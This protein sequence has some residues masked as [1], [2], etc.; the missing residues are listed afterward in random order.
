MRQRVAMPFLKKK[1]IPSTDLK[2]IMVPVA[3][4]RLCAQKSKHFIWKING[5]QGVE[6][7]WGHLWLPETRGGLCSTTDKVSGK[8]HKV[9]CWGQGSGCLVQAQTQTWLWFSKLFFVGVCG[10]TQMGS[11]RKGEVTGYGYHTKKMGQWYT[12]SLA[13][14]Y[15]HRENTSLPWYQIGWETQIPKRKSTDKQQG[16]LK[17]QGVRNGLHTKQHN[18]VP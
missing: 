8:G 7:T 1:K 9:C 14:E 16:Q 17:T 12:T 4:R 18:S 5:S 15:T 10:N 3:C 6:A 11:L 2:G 13:P